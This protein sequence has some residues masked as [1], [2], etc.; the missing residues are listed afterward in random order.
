MRDEGRCCKAVKAARTFQRVAHVRLCQ[1]LAAL[2]RLGRLQGGREWAARRLPARQARRRVLLLLLL[3]VSALVPG[4]ACARGAAVARRGEVTAPALT[5]ACAPTRRSPPQL[6]ARARRG[7]TPR[8][9]LAWRRVD[10]SAGPDCPLSRASSAAP[11]SPPSGDTHSGVASHGGVY[12]RDKARARHVRPAR[13]QGRAAT[14]TAA[15]PAPTPRGHSAAPSPAT[16]VVPMTAAERAA[17]RRS[18]ALAAAAAKGEA[19][20][21]AGGGLLSP[22]NLSATGTLQVAKDRRSGLRGRATGPQQLHSWRLADGEWWARSGTNCGAFTF[23]KK[24][25]RGKTGRRVK[26]APTV[27]WLR[28]VVQ[29]AWPR[30]A[31]PHAALRRSSRQRRA[32]RAP[33]QRCPRA[34]RRPARAGVA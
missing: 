14:A 1:Q 34:G 3:L 12:R 30:D 11:I 13:R 9:T 10:A 22:L 17:T 19:E 32:A 20:G 25:R 2:G 21:Q 18:R 8:R 31:L 4:H 27:L 33:Q 29:R 16:E 7:A 23:L 28:C 6:D 5:R 26:R 24:W 15:A